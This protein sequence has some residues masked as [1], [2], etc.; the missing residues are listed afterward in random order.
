MDI[1]LT[2]LDSGIGAL[3]NGLAKRPK[4]G[5]EE[6]TFVDWLKQSLQTVNKMKNDADLAAQKLVSGENKD[7]HATMISMQKAN[8]AMHL[9]TEVRNKIVTAYDGIKRMQF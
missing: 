5:E 1:K 9:M 3:E 6:T 2:P 4:A 7:I 8:V